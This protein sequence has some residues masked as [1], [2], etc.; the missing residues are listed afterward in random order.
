MKKKS[1]SLE[2][3]PEEI[4]IQVLIHLGPSLER[5]R[6]LR[7]WT[8]EDLARKAGVRQATISDIETNRK[9]PTMKTFFLIVSTL[10]FDIKLHRRSKS[11]NPYEGLF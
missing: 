5:L 6:K 4:K 9:V 11:K 3:L 10:E 1:T 8:Q 7:G 2:T